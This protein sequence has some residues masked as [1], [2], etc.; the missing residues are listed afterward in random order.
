MG[1]RQS[2][3]LKFVVFRCYQKFNLEDY[4]VSHNLCACVACFSWS[5][6][7]IIIQI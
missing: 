4:I 1:A 2:D 6:I 7:I 3:T 5:T